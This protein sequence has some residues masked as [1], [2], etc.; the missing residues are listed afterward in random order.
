MTEGTAKFYLGEMISMT[1]GVDGWVVDNDTDM[2]N[3]SMFILNSL[4]RHRE[5]DWGDLDESDKKANDEAVA[6]GSRILSAYDIPRGHS[7]G[8]GAGD[9]K[10]WIITEADRSSTTIMWPSEY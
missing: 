1:D 3:R 10:V 4:Q 5:G 8:P 6:E 7:G 2:I 9:V